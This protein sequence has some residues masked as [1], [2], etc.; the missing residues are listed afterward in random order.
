MSYKYS[1]R[2]FSALGRSGERVSV[3]MTW[4]AGGKEVSILCPSH[5]IICELAR[6]AV[7]TAPA[8]VYIH[9]MYVHVCIHIC[10]YTYMYVYIYIQIYIYIYLHK[11]MCIYIYTCIH[12]CIYIYETQHLMSVTYNH[13][14]TR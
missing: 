14:R 9:Y 3:S 1:S 11:Y 13:W 4:W 10:M 8:N 12:I 2:T 7:T 5:I 6:F